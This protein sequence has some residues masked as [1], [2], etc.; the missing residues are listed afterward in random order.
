M[1]ETLH[2]AVM[3]SEAPGPTA[4]NHHGHAACFPYSAEFFVDDRKRLL[5]EGGSV[6]RR[7]QE[8]FSV[9]CLL[10]Q[11]QHGQGEWV[12]VGGN[13]QELVEKAKVELSTAK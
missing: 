6:V 12:K 7:I 9:A 2:S 3:S 1:V 11:S 8:L 5:R 13:S 4:A 10:T